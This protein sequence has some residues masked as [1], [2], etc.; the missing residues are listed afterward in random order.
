MALTS[1][2]SNLFNKINA[3]V[4]VIWQ[5]TAF[6]PDIAIIL[7]TGLGNL[8]KRVTKEIAIDYESIPHFPRSTV[9]SHAGKLLFGVLG[10]KKV[11]V[12]DGRFHYYEGYTLEQVTFPVRVLRKLGA[13]ILVVS[14]AAGGLNLSYK[15]GEIVLIEDHINLMGV[16]PLVG[17]NDHR[18]G[19]RFPDM[20]EPYS[21]R[22]M[23]VAEEAARSKRV[24]LKRG[25]YLAITGP[26]L[27]TRAEYRFMRQLGAD[28]VGMSTVPEVIVGVHAGFE[29]LGLSVVT[30][31][32]DPDHLEPVNIEEIIRTAAQAGP[33]LDQ[34]V[35]SFIH[36]LPHVS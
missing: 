23:E 22:L 13:K 10:A 29:I 33:K 32:C 5:K 20:S 4:R 35:E 14:N 34:L 11:V 3:S 16:N 15:K 30:D 27:E 2:K 17:P 19:V 1:G 9:Q 25:T 24:S 26:N 12:M 8:S 6:R 7:G 28:L 18:L 36:Q 31:V 21:K